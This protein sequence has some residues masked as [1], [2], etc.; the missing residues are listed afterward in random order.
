[1]AILLKPTRQGNSFSPFQVLSPAVKSYDRCLLS[2]HS[3]AKLQL[4]QEMHFSRRFR[5]R[6]LDLATA[7]AFGGRSFDSTGMLFVYRSTQIS[8]SMSMCMYMCVYVSMYRY[9]HMYVCMYVYVHMYLCMSMC[10]YVS[11]QAVQARTAA[12]TCG[13]QG[14][15]KARCRALGG[16]Q[17]CYRHW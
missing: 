16:V 10:I 15:E 14:P 8:M 17:S 3:A 11:T 7:L 13:A 12:G 1:M 5:R 9:M 6:A 4:R 2:G